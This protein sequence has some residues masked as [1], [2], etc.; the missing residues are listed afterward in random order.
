MAFMSP[1]KSEDPMISKNLIGDLSFFV[2]EKITYINLS[3]KLLQ[4]KFENEKIFL[5][6]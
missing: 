2:C 3:V 1:Y 6:K 5:C 4:R